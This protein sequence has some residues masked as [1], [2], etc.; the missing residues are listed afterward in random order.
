MPIRPGASVRT[1]E[2][3]VGHGKTMVELFARSTAPNWT[4][5]GNEVGKIPQ[6]C[7]LRTQGRGC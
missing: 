6:Y 1:S 2:E 7:T 3:Y 4:A 5:L